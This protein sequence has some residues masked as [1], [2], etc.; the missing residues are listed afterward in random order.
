VALAVL[1]PN[2]HIQ[3]SM[4]IGIEF[5]DERDP[6]AGDQI[7]QFVVALEGADPVG[8]VDTYARANIEH[9]TDL[10]QHVISTDNNLGG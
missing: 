8:I 3:N 4:V 5:M 10:Y 1:R 9:E 7:R 6:G 2:R